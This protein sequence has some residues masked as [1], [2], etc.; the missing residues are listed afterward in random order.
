MPQGKTPSLA[1]Q[2]SS[3]S[4]EDS[5]ALLAT[6]QVNASH[7]NNVPLPVDLGRPLDADEEVYSYVVNPG[8]RYCPSLV[9][10][11]RHP[12]YAQSERGKL[13]R[14]FVLK[15]QQAAAAQR[16]AQMREAAAAL[17]PATPLAIESSNQVQPVNQQL[18]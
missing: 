3:L 8:A 9:V 1:E 12:K 14:A 6:L 10:K 4:P 2:L 16:E 15:Q 5:A 17:T 7:A 11:G 13:A 18:S